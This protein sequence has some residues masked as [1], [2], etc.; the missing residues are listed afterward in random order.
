MKESAINNT[1]FS[2]LL[3]IY[4]LLRHKFEGFKRINGF[5]LQDQLNLKI[6]PI[7]LKIKTR[8]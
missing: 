6:E 8:T 2:T 7:T 5:Y 3:L 4:N 1:Q